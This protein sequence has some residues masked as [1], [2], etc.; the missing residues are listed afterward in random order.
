MKHFH[1]KTTGETVGEGFAGLNDR[2]W[3][4][5]T[6][7]EIAAI[8]AAKVTPEERIASLLG[9]IAAERDRRANALAK[10]YS[11]TEQ[12][13]WHVQVAEAQALLSDPDAPAPMLRAIAPSRGRTPQEIAAHVLHLAAALAAATGRIFAAGRVLSDAASA[14][15]LA[16]DWTNDRHWV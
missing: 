8:Q 5:V 7:D 11:E 12:K 4:E 10:D 14:G 3:R 6:M 2:D 16:E 9:Q 1:N 13:T 15:T